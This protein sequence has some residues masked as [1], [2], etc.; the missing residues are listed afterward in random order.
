MSE[1]KLPEVW[2]RGPLP[3]INPFLQPIAHALLQAKDEVTELMEDF[4]DK[5]LWEQPAGVASPAFH[6][7]PRGASLR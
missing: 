2:L 3:G 7:L 6:L 1:S 5:L 4:P